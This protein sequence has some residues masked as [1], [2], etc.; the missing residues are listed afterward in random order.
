MFFRKISAAVEQ[1]IESKPFNVIVILFIIF[2]SIFLALEYD[3]MP[4]RMSRVINI[5]N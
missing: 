3:N 2:N 4:V 1:V 5:G